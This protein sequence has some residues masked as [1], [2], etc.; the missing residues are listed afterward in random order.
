MKTNKGFTLTEVLL[1]MMIVGI[2]GIALAALTT[3]AS[4]DSGQSSSKIMLRNNLSIFMRQLRQDVHDASSVESAN[5]GN[6]PYDKDNYKELITLVKNLTINHIQIHDG[7]VVHVVYCFKAGSRSAVSD[8]NSTAYIE[9]Q[10]KR[11][12]YEGDAP[13]G[14]TCAKNGNVVLNNVKWMSSSTSKYPYFQ[15][16][17]TLNSIL[18]IKL[19]VE[20]P[21]TPVINDAVEERFMLPNGY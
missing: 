20:I 4:R 15:T 3:S 10:I 6:I 11:W 18:H 16:I 21:S 17:G 8:D 9:G 2:I 13:S 19:I 7:A 5:T 14:G 1:G 12:Q